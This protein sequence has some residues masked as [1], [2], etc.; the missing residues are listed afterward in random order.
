ML[1]HVLFAPP[2]HC[3]FPPSCC[4]LGSGLV[5][6]HQLA[7]VTTG[8]HWV[9]QGGSSIQ[10]ISFPCF[11]PPF[12]WLG[13]DLSVGM[14]IPWDLLLQPQLLSASGNHPLLVPFEA[15][16][17]TR[18]PPPASSSVLYYSLLVSFHYFHM[19]L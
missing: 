4:V 18:C 11:P 17:G 19:T 12:P 14:L 6:R 13:G 2:D 10:D 3:P 1:G 8:F 15:Q 16:V 5:W 7:R 9:W